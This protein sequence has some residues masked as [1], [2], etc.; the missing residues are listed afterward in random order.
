[1]FLLTEAM[2]DTESDQHGDTE[3]TGMIQGLALFRDLR[4]SVVITLRVLGP[5]R[6]LPSG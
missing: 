5:L 2:E 1:M 6:G 3:G 4:V